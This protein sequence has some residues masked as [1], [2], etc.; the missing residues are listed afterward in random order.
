MSFDILILLLNAVLQL[1]ALLSWEVWDSNPQFK[2]LNYH[3]S[4][5]V[6]FYF[7]VAPVS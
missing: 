7:P 2:Y 3:F 1:S 5:F 6:K 4:S